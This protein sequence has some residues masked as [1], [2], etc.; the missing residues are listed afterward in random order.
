MENKN[1]ISNRSIKYQEEI[2][3]WTDQNT[4]MVEF[5][6]YVNK[7]TSELMEEFNL[8]EVFFDHYR[9]K[10]TSNFNNNNKKKNY[11]KQKKIS[12]IS[13]LYE[14]NDISAISV[15]PLIKL[16]KTKNITKFNSINHDFRIHLTKN[17][18]VHV[19]YQ[20]PKDWYVIHKKPSNKYKIKTIPK[21]NKLFF[22]HSWPS[23]IL[24][25]GILTSVLLLTTFVYVQNI[26]DPSLKTHLNVYTYF[27][28]IFNITL[29]GSPS[30]ILRNSKIFFGI[31]ALTYIAIIILPLLIFKRRIILK[32]FLI[33]LNIINII[34][35]GNDVY[36][37]IFYD[38]INNLFS[39][40]LEMYTIW[41]LLIFSWLFLLYFHI[42]K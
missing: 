37:L 12:K 35:L 34:W 15:T 38:K 40:I 23:F 9:P 8:I 26:F 29:S 39:I 36:A 27:T 18:W 42:F 33:F 24:R 5:I 16:S 22:W 31:I 17:K 4:E 20:Q 41:S 10:V 6:E 21:W 7:S 28:S 32:I 2:L 25:I 13:G 14:K 3:E 11:Q 19:G 1:I 30:E